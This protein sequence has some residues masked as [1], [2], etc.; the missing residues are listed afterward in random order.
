[1][2]SGTPLDRAEQTLTGIRVAVL[3]LGECIGGV[4]ELLWG[5]T[6]LLGGVPAEPSGG[7]FGVQR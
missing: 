7:R 2:V 3:K 4:G 5:H 1:M 6:T